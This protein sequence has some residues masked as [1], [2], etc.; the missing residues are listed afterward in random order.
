MIVAERDAVKSFPTPQN[1]NPKILN[2]VGGGPVRELRWVGG[3]DAACLVLGRWPRWWLGRGV[4]A[5]SSWMRGGRR[6]SGLPGSLGL[7]QREGPSTLLT[8]L[9]LLPL[10][11][12]NI[13]GPVFG[14]DAVSDQLPMEELWQEGRVR[15]LHVPACGPWNVQKYRETAQHR[16]APHSSATGSFSCYFLGGRVSLNLGDEIPRLA[17]ACTEFRILSIPSLPLIRVAG[18]QVSS[19]LHQANC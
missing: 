2:P 16:T 17:V 12:L 6:G 14:L 13:R 9:L 5:T 10:L 1:L 18:S 15:E 19:R 11:G 7:A 8:G 4:V 3:R